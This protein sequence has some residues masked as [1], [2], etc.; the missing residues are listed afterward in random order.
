MHRAILTAALILTTAP[1]LA[2]GP[3][4][5][6]ADRLDCAA[7]RV[8]HARPVDSDRARRLD[9][10]PQGRTYLLVMREVNG[11]HEPV[12]ASEE[13]TRRLRRR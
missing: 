1:G 11:C 4:R 6:K 8:Q 3:L 2:A 9:E 13:R 5:P 10:L 12:L 7:A